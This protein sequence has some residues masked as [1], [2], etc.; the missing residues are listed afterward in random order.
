MA[1][2]IVY[3]RYCE[4]TG[5]AEIWGETIYPPLKLIDF[6]SIV[7]DVLQFLSCVQINVTVFRTNSKNSHMGEHFQGLFLIFGFSQSRKESTG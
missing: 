4:I 2:E 5:T 1:V 6:L 7:K 3:I